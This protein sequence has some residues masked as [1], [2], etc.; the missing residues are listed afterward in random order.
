L[1]KEKKKTE[2]F[3]MEIE[4]LPQILKRNVQTYRSTQVAMRKKERGIWKTYTW[5]DLFSR[6]KKLA[7]AL[8]KLGVI[9][10]DAVGLIGDNGPELFWAELGIQSTNAHA[11]L[12][13]AHFSIQSMEMIVEELKITLLLVQNV[14]LAERVKKIRSKLSKVTKMIV[15]SDEKP[16]PDHDPW[17]IS[18]AEME[19][20]VQEF[21]ASY[22]D[23][24]EKAVSR[25]RS[26]SLC[27]LL[28]NSDSKRPIAD[29][30]LTHESLIKNVQAF[31]AAEPRSIADD[32][33]S[34]MPATSF[35]EQSL[36]LTASLLSGCKLNF[37]E[38]PESA[39]RDIS[40][41]SPHFIYS[42]PKALESLAEAVNERFQESGP[43]V[44]RMYN[45]L[46]PPRLKQ[47]TPGAECLGPRRFGGATW[48]VGD[49]LLFRH[50]RRRMGL[51]RA[52]AV[53]TNQSQAKL[54]ICGA[55]RALGINV[56]PVYRSPENEICLNRGT[57]VMESRGI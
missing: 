34:I 53:Y 8:T 50:A 7:L 44:K 47:M 32:Y 35:W 27:V 31:V 9:E 56:K 49:V 38:K 37:C 13:G 54:E 21:S 40:E 20:M 51:S 16:S 6:A 15:L 2:E 23:V 14:E 19:K 24:F 28:Y 5:V 43:L 10:N 25:T 57:G 46:L 17:Y 26:K 55:L 22:P 33:M 36:G 29:A 52:K 30:A 1:A 48:W 45:V 4:T 3:H 39:K 42:E 18:F 12:I 41:I 11:V